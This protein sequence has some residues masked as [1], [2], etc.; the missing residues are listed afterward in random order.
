MPDPREENLRKLWRALEALD[1]RPLALG[2]LQQ[3]ELP[4][5]WSPEALLDHGNRDLATAH[6]RVDIL[7]YVHGKLETPE[8]YD[9]LAGKAE[10]VDIGFG[11]FLV[12]GYEDLIDL[13]TLAGRDQDLTD[14]RALREARDETSAG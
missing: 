5:G 14:I 10:P 8:D 12:V 6:G 3:K 4:V 7:Q 1:A 13:K 11:V 9:A 2:D